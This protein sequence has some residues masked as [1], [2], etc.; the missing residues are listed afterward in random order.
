MPPRHTVALLIIFGIIALFHALHAPA[1]GFERR[2]FLFIAA[3]AVVTAHARHV[4]R[5][6]FATIMPRDFEAQIL[7]ERYWRQSR[8][9][10]PSSEHFSP[11]PLRE[12][13]HFIF[14]AIVIFCFL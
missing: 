1:V 8:R 7:Q 14:V 9:C 12:P 10:P 6:C 13:F 11:S 2:R 3:T 4:S 5:C